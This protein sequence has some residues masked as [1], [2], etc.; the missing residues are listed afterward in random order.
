M[1]NNVYSIKN[2]YVFALSYESFNA[3]S[4]SFHASSSSFHS[5]LISNAS[6]ESL[7]DSTVQSLTSLV[8][9]TELCGKLLDIDLIRAR[10]ELQSMTETIR[11]IINDM[12][13]IIYDLHPTSLN[14]FGLDA[15]IDSYCTRINSFI[16]NS[17]N[18][19]S[20]SSDSFLFLTAAISKPAP[21]SSIS[22]LVFSSS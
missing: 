19:Q 21:S 7:H 3:G 13:E 12:R 4:S 8:H 11:A 22:N 6:T 10:L 1:E 9:K 5:A 20:S 15:A 17:P 2:E 18:P 16:V 14:N